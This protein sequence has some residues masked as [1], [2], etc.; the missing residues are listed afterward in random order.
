MI[1]SSE[2]TASKNKNR[3][4]GSSKLFNKNFF[5]LFQGQL[6]SN[7]GNQIYNIAMMLWIKQTT[8]MAWLMG[9]MLMA[10]RIPDIILGPI[11]GTFVD[12]LP[13]KKIIV[14]TDLLSGVVVALIAVLIIFFPGET[15]LLLPCIFIAAVL[16]GGFLSFLS[17]AVI[18][19]LP[20]LLCKKKL[21]AGNSLISA[22]DEGSVFIG[23]ALGG[24][25]YTALG[26][27]LCFLING[28]SYLFSSATEMFITLPETHLKKGENKRKQKSFKEDLK[29]GFRY[30]WKNK[31]LRN[32]A[33]IVALQNF[34][35][36]PIVILL[37]FYV[38]SNLKS[39]PEWFGFLLSAYS[40]GNI[41]G[42]LLAG[43]S[44]IPG[45]IRWRII[46][47][48]YVM[49]FIFLV[50]IGI[51]HVNLIALLCIFFAGLFC[52]FTDVHILT[53]LQLI[54][55]VKMRGRLFGLLGTLSKILV[56]VGMGLSGIIADLLDKDIPSMFIGMG[57]TA[58]VLSLLAFASKDLRRILSYE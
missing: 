10:S 7:I 13:R 46:L 14:L 6:V 11:G 44:T 37:P 40:F 35:I 34:F 8:G 29:Q 25:L 47:S 55:P 48:S 36:A 12:R 27:A 18:A 30:V 24:V 39:G 17:P 28:A 51:V 49:I 31:G 9:L 38:D 23:Q 56:P 2:S 41:V 5:L 26:A 54:T 57:M 33:F 42:Y 52:G 50:L 22:S 19:S 53:I 1:M 20:D 58:T 21:K 15:N 4:L 3:G 43:I 45:R 32:S 16:L